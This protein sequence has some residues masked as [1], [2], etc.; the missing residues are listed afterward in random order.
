MR[1]ALGRLAV[2]SAVV[3]RTTARR[4]AAGRAAVRGTVSLA[5]LSEGCLEVLQKYN[6]RHSTSSIIA[7]VQS[8]SAGQSPLTIRHTLPELC[9]DETMGKETEDRANR[10]G[11]TRCAARYL[12]RQTGEF[13][14]L[15]LFLRQLYVSA[16]RVSCMDECHW[17]VTEKKC[18]RDIGQ[19]ISD[20]YRHSSK[21]DIKIQYDQRQH[22]SDA[23][24]TR[25]M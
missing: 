3:K 21:S 8:F 4:A 12:E 23:G 2:K 5:C 19:A 17:S 15:M 20:I 1:S 18:C 9:D 25:D 14:S 7:D 16:M 13:A 6:R 22:G 11:L 24:P 10:A